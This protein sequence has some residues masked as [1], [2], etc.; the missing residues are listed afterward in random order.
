MLWYPLKERRAPDALAKHLRA[1]GLPK[2]LR[3]ELTIGAL[4]PTGPLAGS[5]IIVVNPPFPLEAE[6][7]VIL[8]VLAST[9]SA[10]G[11]C[12]GSIGWPKNGRGPLFHSLDLV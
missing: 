1:L 9:L 3:A 7:R 11:Q 5:G 10:Q 12:T 4:D 6:L 8:P 2:L